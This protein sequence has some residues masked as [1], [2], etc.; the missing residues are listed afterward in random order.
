MLRISALFAALLPLALTA[1]KAGAVG[2]AIE[3]DKPTAS[4][5][6]DELECSEDQSRAEPLIVDWGSDD[7]T[8]LEVAM[9]DGI[10]VVSYDCN[11][12]RVLETC[13][14]PGG[15]SFAGV[16]RKE[17][18][19][20]IVGQD[21]LHANFPLGGAKFEAGLDRNSAIDVALVTIGKHRAAASKVNQG[22]LQGECEGATHFVSSALVGAFAVGTGTRGHAGTVAEVFKL[23]DVGGS[24]TS[25]QTSLNR[26]GDL[27]ACAAATPLDP[28]P[29][30]QCQSLLRVELVALGGN[31]AAEGEVAAANG[32]PEATPL[33]NVCTVEG[34]VWDGQKCTS[35]K[36]AKGYRCKADDAAECKAQCELGNA[37]S[38]YNLAAMTNAGRGGLTADREAATALYDKACEGDNLQACTMLV[39]RLDWKA[40]S[41]RVM[42][43]LQK[44]CEGGDAV[45][46]RVFGD[47]LIL[48]NRL[49]KDPA[50][51]EQLLVGA[52]AMAEMFA[53]VNLASYVYDEKKQADRAL[54]IAE[55]SCKL[56]NGLSCSLQAGWQ[57]RCE[58]GRPPGVSPARVKTCEKFPNTNANQ[59]TLAYEAAC[60]SSSLGACVLAGNRYAKGKGVTAD[61]V[62]AHE[63]YTLGCPRGADS[64]T[65]LGRTYEDGKGVK[66]DLNQAYAA[67]AKG[68][69]SLDKGD[70]YEAARVAKKL[71]NDTDYRARLE[72]GCQKSS[73]RACDELTKLL[74]KEKKTDEAKAIYGD[75]CQRMKEKPYCDAFKR[76]GG[77]L[78]EDFKTFKKPE[79]RDP[80]DF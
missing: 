78:P 43:L 47:E 61:L 76:L 36:Q 27:A 73:R 68:C 45:A 56:G 7:R 2:A 49:P 69:D 54:Q 29:P 31:E 34:F 8:D 77:E 28:A 21:E 26:D 74:E 11:S 48:G 59:A 58:D 17:D 19:I 14:A 4:D 37:D 57:S 44:T 60:R 18:V 33:E 46:C 20:Q 13:K 16:G 64:C 50:R 32:A 25:E 41:E 5:A 66:A 22:D 15:Y 23:G 42:G 3:P 63:L 24:S 39:Y 30:A 71:G 6:M 10:V 9:R 67:Y 70:C 55:S 65:A 12:F 38:C 52:C 79:T 53:C 1:C 72:K 35:A 62:K 75:V 80:D 51:G 40:E